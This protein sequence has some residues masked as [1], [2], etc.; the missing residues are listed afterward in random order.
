MGDTCKSKIAG[1]KVQTSTEPLGQFQPKLA[2]Y[3]HPWVML[4]KEHS[5]FYGKRRD[6]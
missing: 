6:V 2:K 3:M 4:I 1:K 5:L